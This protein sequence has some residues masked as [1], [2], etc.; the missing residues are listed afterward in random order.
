MKNRMLKKGLVV[1]IICLLML[2]YMPTTIGTEDFNLGVSI[3]VR[4]VLPRIYLE[5]RN[6]TFEIWVINDG[7]EDCNNVTVNLSYTTLFSPFVDKP[8]ATKYDEFE[9]SLI[10]AGKSLGKYIHHHCGSIGPIG[11]GAVYKIT[12]TLD[13]DDI[14]PSDNSDSFIFI[15]IGY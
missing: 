9:M 10:P 6:A 5:G 8:W 11:L 13:I 14:K 2:V 4:R 3:I 1:G 12:A 15:V 7:P